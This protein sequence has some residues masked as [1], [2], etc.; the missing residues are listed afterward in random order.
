MA[1]DGNVA[2]VR[3]LD[4][5]AS[6]GCLLVLLDG[7]EMALDGSFVRVVGCLNLKL[8]RPPQTTSKLVLRCK[9]TVL[10]WH[11]LVGAGQSLLEV[12]AKIPPFPKEAQDVVGLY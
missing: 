3:R 12:G 11:V 1:S 10:R 9:A 8:C 6:E 2:D 7:M 5:T 4:S